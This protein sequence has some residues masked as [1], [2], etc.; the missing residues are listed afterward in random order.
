MGDSYVHGF[1]K[2]TGT[3]DSYSEVYIDA[4]TG[5][6]T[7]QSSAL[8]AGGHETIYLYNSRITTNSL[9]MVTTGYSN[10]CQPVVY[11]SIPDNG[12][13]TI[14]VTNMGPNACIGAFTLNF[15]VIN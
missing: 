4:M 10:N 7:S 15:I 6:I 2:G 3:A 9:F 8:A 14:R 5:S 13:V 12:D 11:Q 1:E